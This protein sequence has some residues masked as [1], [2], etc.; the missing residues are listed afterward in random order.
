MCLLERMR[1]NAIAIAGRETSSRKEQRTLTVAKS[2]PLLTEGGNV[3]I[4]KQKNVNGNYDHDR[5]DDPKPE[6]PT[7]PL[8]VGGLERFPFL[9]SL[10]PF[11]EGFTPPPYP[12]PWA[13]TGRPAGS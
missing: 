8:G 7:S 12:L 10:F 1:E 11:G 6:N 5:H 13:W 3:D 9:P 2:Q 4:E